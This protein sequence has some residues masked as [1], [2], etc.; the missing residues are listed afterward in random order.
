VLRLHVFGAAHILDHAGE[1]FGGA[2][3]TRRTL[4]LLAVLAVAG[5]AG[6][7]RDKL[8]GLLWPESETERARHSLTQAMYTARRGLRCDELFLASADVRLNP[9]QITSDLFEFESAC[10][11]SD[12]ERAVRLYPGPFLDGFFLQ[13]SPEFEEWSSEHRARYENRIAGLL[14]QLALSAEAADDA[15]CAVEWWRRLAALHPLD[16]RVAKRVMQSMATA[17]DKAGALQHARIHETML[18]DQLG[19]F[20]DT[21]VTE[22]AHRLRTSSGVGA[23]SMVVSPPTSPAYLTSSDANE[24]PDGRARTQQGVTVPRP[25]RRRLWWPATLALGAT[26]TAVV[27]ILAPKRRQTVP[28]IEAL[29][30]HQGV[31]VAPFRVAGA[32]SELQYLREGIVELL[33]S[34]LVDDSAAG[35][36]DAGAVLGA[37]RS[38]GLVQRAEAPRDLVVKLA[39]RLGARRVVV[40]SIVGSPSRLIIDA[41]ILAVPGGEP[42]SRATAEGPVD[43]ISIVIDRLAAT[44]LLAE[45]AEATPAGRMTRSLPALRAYLEGERAVRRAGY[46]AALAAYDRALR[47][48]STF[49]IAALR[50]AIVADRVSDAA[51]NHHGVAL[52]WSARQNLGAS[53][54]ALLTSFVGA[55]Y[56]APSAAEQQLSAWRAAVDNAPR[57]VEAWIA[58]GARLFHDGEVTGVAEAAE[59][60]RSALERALAINPRSA[61]A[62]E[63]LM[64]VGYRADGRIAVD[65]TWRAAVL[66][67]SLSPIAPFLRWR[68]RTTGTTAPTGP[69]RSDSAIGPSRAQFGQ[70]R[71]SALRLIAMA[72][73]YDAI[74]G[75]DGERAVALMLDRANDER[76]RA[77]ALEALHSLRLNQG[78]QREALD[79]T[80][81]LRN[82]QP[83]NP[84]AYLRLRILD[85]LYGDGDTGAAISAAKELQAFA[86]AGLSAAP[87][88]GATWYADRC[89]LAQWRLE[90]QD[91]TGVRRTIEELR[92]QE[93]ISQPPRVFA[94]PIACAELLDAS[95][96]VVSRRRDAKDRL[97]RVDA[98]AFTPQTAGDAVAY[99]PLLLARL[100]SRLGDTAA[101]LRALKKRSYM[102]LW[103]RYLATIRRE[104]ATLMRNRGS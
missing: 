36:V 20:P 31:V 85:A 51:A 1:P 6:V 66:G 38:S 26:A 81:R 68:A 59:R 69:P 4:G 21:S 97:A 94:A 29:A 3:A 103:P 55:R 95:L 11:R 99:A 27:L 10:A 50:L 86:G 18:R 92:R 17:G 53:D 2:V 54:L 84:H 5:D 57:S 23:K 70:L 48:D 60:A 104:E 72:S 24:S 37:W 77:D 58:L 64:Q 22:L 71:V 15:R 100:H 9:A 98:L 101:A 75:D 41:S 35:L 28:D 13:G 87:V 25:L 43:S 40:G 44:L 33:S 96:A 90:H 65:S 52:A 89:V 61:N 49:A 93:F 80:T 83:T 42:V 102:S 34:R 73:Q 12:P 19:I 76:S 62:A 56:P 74:A 67:D 32:T 14:E 30:L 16:S 45:A 78:R 39:A 8:V 82:V 7:S 91:T 47:L 63:L 79:V 88:T 46:R